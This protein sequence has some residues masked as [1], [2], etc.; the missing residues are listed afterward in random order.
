MSIALK[1]VGDLPTTLEADQVAELLGI[2]K[3]TLYELNRRGEAP[4]Q[5]LHLGRTLRW[6]TAAV[7]RVL[8]IDPA[9]RPE[10]DENPAPG[11]ALEGDAPDRSH[12]SKGRTHHERPD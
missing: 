4:V 2:S 9:A 1:D 7:L 8:G 12:E 11:G 6:P 3:W 5:P 10:R